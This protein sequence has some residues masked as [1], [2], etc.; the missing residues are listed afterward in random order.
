[1][2]KSFLGVKASAGK[3]VYGSFTV[4]NVHIPLVV[5]AGRADDG[6]TLVIHCAQHATEYS[7]SA[8]IGPLLAGLDL[9]AMCGTLVVVPL[10]HAP[11]IARLRLPELYQPIADEL[12]P[13]EGTLAANINRCWPGKADG[14][15]NDRLTYTL[16]H[17]LFAQADAVLDYHSCRLCDPNFTSYQH[18]HQGSREL[19]LAFGFDVID[20]APDEGH[21][22][23]QCHR[24][25]PRQIGTPAILV[26]MSPSANQTNWQV[27]CEAK[28][29]ALNALR[30]LGMV[31]GKLDLPARQVIYHRGA[32]TACL[33]ASQIGFGVTYHRPGALVRKGELVA[34][35]RSLKDFSVLE[36]LTAP[37]DGGA[38]S[39]GPEKHHVVLPGEE[40]ASVQ[41]DVEV[42]KNE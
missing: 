3:V 41:K 20:E 22:P 29:G 14:H 4:G 15:F 2:S 34:E 31:K 11:Q 28:R 5:A 17:E 1:M 37:F 35:V 25:V 26:E 7:G 38:G 30:H 19:A 12:K 40:L 36:R 27:I 23:G 18:G 6:P 9:A 10:C 21:F 33:R 42:V 32:E 8:M 13:L 39:C 16:S 24:E